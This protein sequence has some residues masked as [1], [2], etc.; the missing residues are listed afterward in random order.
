MLLDSPID[1]QGLPAPIELSYLWQLRLRPID[2]LYGGMAP[3]ADRLGAVVA[4]CLA[5]LREA[6]LCHALGS[7]IRETYP[8]VSLRRKKLPAPKGWSAV[9]HSDGRVDGIGSTVKRNDA[10]LERLEQEVPELLAGLK[11]RSS[12]S[13][14]KI[15]DH[16]VDAVVCGLIGISPRPADLI[17][18]LAKKFNGRG[19]VPPRG[20]V[21]DMD[22]PVW[23]S[24][25]SLSRQRADLEPTSKP[26]SPVHTTSLET[27]GTPCPAGCGK[28]FKQWPLGADAHAKSLA[29]RTK[30]TGIPVELT[31]PMERWHW[32]RQ[33]SL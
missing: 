28:I 24:S 12:E 26:T 19:Y 20:Y 30:C 25:I 15:S 3:L 32:Y 10:Q 4:R 14:I 18:E 6:G 17:A 13:A 8:G 22:G 9:L 23:W 21:M 1:L 27:P 29:H 33:R 16:E 7:Q 2:Q 31:A 5:T 11:L